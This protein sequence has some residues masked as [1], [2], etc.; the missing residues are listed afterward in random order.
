MRGNTYA[1]GH[2]MPTRRKI[3]AI[4]NGQ[5]IKCYYCIADAAKD[6][7]TIANISKVLKGTRNHAHYLQWK[8]V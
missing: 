4:R 1:V 7:Y 6:G 3:L 2:I 8:Y 5:P